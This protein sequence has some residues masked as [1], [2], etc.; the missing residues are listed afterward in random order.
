MTDAQVEVRLAPQA[1]RFEIVVDG[2]VAGH[3]RFHDHAG[4]RTFV[5]TEIDPAREGQGLGGRLVRE[6]LDQTRA[7][8][9]QVDPQCPFVRAFIDDHQE[10]AD[11]LAAA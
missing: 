10:Y 9:L 7:S 1:S 5:H 4:V 8:G 6:A 11:L 3:T 2:D